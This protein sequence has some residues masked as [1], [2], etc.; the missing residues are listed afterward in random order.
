VKK[1]LILLF[2][3]LILHSCQ[4]KLQVLSG[5]DGIEVRMIENNEELVRVELVNNSGY[6]L[7]MEST[8]HLF[9]QRKV[10][11]EWERVAYVPCQCGTPCMDPRPVKIDVGGTQ[12]VE[13]DLF[14]R[15]CKSD[16]TGIQTI[17]SRVSSGVYR[18][19]F[20]LNPSKNGNRLNPEVL[21]V[22]FKVK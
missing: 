15:G 20:V 17:Q 14:T 11:D 8:R 5:L 1:Y 4:S 12:V 21:N 6:T 13:W 19:K 3:I 9:I 10:G 7:H 18:L 2:A 22:G 16:E